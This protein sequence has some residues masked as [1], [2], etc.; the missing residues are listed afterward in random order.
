MKLNNLIYT[1]ILVFCLV[2]LT[3][4][5]QADGNKTGSEYMMD[6][7]HSIAY[8]IN[9]SNYYKLNTWGEQEEYHAYVQ[10]RLPQKGTIPRG[11][12]GYDPSDNE[13]KARFA[14]LNQGLPTSGFV[15]YY[16]DGSTEG[17]DKAIAEIIMNPFPIT[18]A[19]LL[20]GKELYN[21]FCGICHGE[22]ADGNGYLVRED[23]GVYPAQPANLISYE[24]VAASNGRFYHSIM[25]GYNVMGAYKDKLSYEERWQVI[26]YIRSL[27]AAEKK[28]AY[29]ESENSLNA[30]MG[31][32]GAS[33]SSM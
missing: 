13:A 16:Y 6:M 27:Q 32:P 19:G 8:E 7:G 1:A 11:F 21:V 14:E 4:C 30:S 29:N 33:K 20:K 10:P 17:R 3:S 15:P 26:H 2:Y 9:T 22:K 24:F 31:K 28:V 5:S 25:H 18:E 23:G 12:A